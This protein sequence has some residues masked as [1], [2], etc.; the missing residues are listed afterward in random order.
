LPIESWFQT[1]KARLDTI[2]REWPTSG[3]SEKI[4]LA[5]QLLELR[6][7]SDKVVD[8]WL[9]YEEN[10]SNV[11]K[12][13]KAGEQQ[14]AVPAEEAAFAQLKQA[15]KGKEVTSAEPPISAAAA[16]QETGNTS[17]S[18]REDAN[19]THLF[20]KGEGFYHLRLFQDAKSHF[21]ELVK[22]S[23]DWEAGRLYYAYS[24]LFCEE[25][26]AAMKEFRL[27]SR[28]ASSPKVAAI[29]YNAIGCLLTEEQQ[30]LEAGQAFKE[31]LEALPTHLHALFNLA[32]CYLREGEAQ[33]A[34]DTIEQYLQYAEDDWEAQ[35]VWLRSARLLDKD[36]TL[37][38]VPPAGLHLPSK[39]LD[40]HTL[41][42]MAE[43][44][45]ANGQIHRAVLCYRYL[46]ERLPGEGWVWHGLAWNS[47]LIGGAKNAMP[48]LKKAIS[49]A[50]DNLDFLFSYGWIKLFDGDQ[51]NALSVFR[52]ILLRNREHRL[53]Q[54]GLITAYER[55]GDYTEAKRL[56]EQF[57]QHADPYLCSLGYYHLG[58]IAVAEE[59]WKL[60]EQYFTRVNAEGDA[61]R[62]V[63]LFLKLCAEKL[64]TS[65][66]P[67]ESL[68]IP[69]PI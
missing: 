13:I 65:V 18:E 30:W 23:P 17:I 45:E 56:A 43:I 46:K 11:I 20:R 49:L 29:S 40:P 7:I 60:A 53:A 59:N 24:L 51:D 63:P 2:E 1:L 67:A 37:E 33:E 62:E 10:L 8:L 19:F 21:A 22:H 61:F 64:G 44:Y 55:A 66:V 52:F 54:S 12:K 58:R 57:V 31:A 9:Q 5:N 35:I 4:R 3:E 26:E 34:L 25:N 32:L 27:L 36:D 69:F 39:Q 16:S 6:Q 68:L 50:P 15:V 38:R 28:S 14:E 41:R 47:W 48:L 42:D